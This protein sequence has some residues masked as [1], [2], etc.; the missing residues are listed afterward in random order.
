MNVL[1]I[2]LRDPFIMMETVKANDRL[3]GYERT[4]S[5]AGRRN[6]PGHLVVGAVNGD[7]YGGSG[8]P[9]NIQVAQG[10]I[11]LT[12][13]NKS[14]IGFDVYDSPM[15][16]VVSFSAVVRR[17]AALLAINGINQT[18]GTDQLILFNKYFGT[19]TGTNIF[20]A[21]ALVRPLS[22]WLV[23]DTLTCV[24]ENVVSGIGNMT[25]VPGKAVLSGHGTSQTW[26]N[27]NLG[28]GDTIKLYQRI[29]PGLSRLKELIGGFPKIVYNGVDYVDQGFAEEGGPS[30]TY[31]RHP[32]TGAGFSADSSKLYLFAV[33]GRQVISA[34]MTLHELATFMI[35]W[36]VYHGI[37]FDGGGSTTMVVRGAVVNA[38]SDGGTERS[39]SNALLAASSAPVDTLNRV[40]LN[41]RGYRI[42]R[43]DTLRY[44]LSGVDRY[45]NPIALTPAL[46]Q[47]S[48]S[49]NLGTIDQTGRFVAAMSGDSGYVRSTYTQFRDS[50]YVV[51][52]S[53]ARV[54]L[55][56]QNA[57]TDT[58]R[59]VTFR[60]RAFDPDGV[61]RTV[62]PGQYIWSS[63]NPTVGT[64]DTVGVFRGRA[65]GATQ[66]IAN[67]QGVRDTAD[68]TIQIG[69]GTTVLDSM[70]SLQRWT[71]TTINCDSVATTLSLQSGISTL[72]SKSLRVN[73]RFVYDPALINYIRL[74]TDIPVFGVPDSILLDIRAD[75]A[76]HRVF[77]YIDDDDA[78]Q[79]RI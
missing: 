72:G 56:P 7:F 52:K 30:H 62:P 59:T 76:N 13:S 67:Y 27:T 23:N 49:P 43:G 44:I 51:I 45:G 60:A 17:G 54:L 4:S 77:Y 39:V 46:M 57:V 16:K 26:I 32:R 19:S 58:V 8:V 10:E 37:N 9:I 29:S 35:G 1:E 73:Y 34:G 50:A 40:V 14:T 25:I 69:V 42:Y 36:G 20:G 79:Y 2:D 65:S 12:P 78:E 74:N 66:V 33:D 24:V 38:P 71:L 3:A 70:E 18:R 64:V 61:E 28:V 31:E 53:I 21:E 41:P 15:L 68:M 11:L 48:V 5:M 22:G 47:F 75:S 63:T 6:Y 55:A